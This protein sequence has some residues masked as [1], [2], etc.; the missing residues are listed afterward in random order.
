MERAQ[1][2]L[3]D[4]AGVA[5]AIES[6]WRDNVHEAVHRDVLAD[7]CDHYLP[8]RECAVLEVGCGTGRIYERLVPRR[9]DN[10]CYTG[11]DLSQ[12]MLALGRARFPA[13]RLL[14]GDGCGLPFR[15][16]AFDVA[17]AF[18]VVGHLPAIGPFLRELV[19]VCRETAIFTIWPAA[20]G[21]V[22]A[23]EI[24]LGARF[25]HRSYSHAYLREQI[26]QELPGEALELEVGILSAEWWAYALRRRAGR[27]G[28]TGPRLLPVPG[29]LERLLAAQ[30]A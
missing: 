20:D 28:L 1:W 13:A 12:R 16:G 19:R 6:Y 3:W 15:D 7:L 17:L 2:Q 25:L 14:A 22:E 27:P 9:I 29:Y 5:E 10:R 11:V 26:E 30:R 8:Q 21:V 18:E 4:R 23:H 24:I